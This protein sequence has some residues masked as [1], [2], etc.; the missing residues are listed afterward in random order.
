MQEFPRF[1]QWLLLN[2][3]LRPDKSSLEI[4]TADLKVWILCQSPE[5]PEL[6]NDARYYPVRGHE[7]LPG[8]QGASPRRAW[9]HYKKLDFTRSFVQGLFHSTLLTTQMPRLQG[10]CPTM[11][12]ESDYSQQWLMS[13][14][15]ISSACFLQSQTERGGNYTEWEMARHHGYFRIAF[16]NWSPRASSQRSRSFLEDF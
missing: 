11:S 8:I 9:G 16:T 12:S 1:V 3:Y 15:Q 5:Y 14:L 4:K 13:S 7:V 2:L 6:I 10:T